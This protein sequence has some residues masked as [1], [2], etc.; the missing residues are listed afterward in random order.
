MERK[1]LLKAKACL[2]HA[3]DLAPSEAYIAKHLKIVETRIEKLR[4]MS[5]ADAEKELAFMEFDAS[6]FGGDNKML[7]EPVV[8]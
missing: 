4:Q 6:E 1:Q 8:N 3:N 2:Q 5:E 7:N